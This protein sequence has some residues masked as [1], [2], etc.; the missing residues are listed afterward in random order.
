MRK[1]RG[2]VECDLYDQLPANAKAEIDPHVCNH[3]LN[4]HKKMCLEISEDAWP[5]VKELIQKFR[6]FKKENPRLFKKP[7]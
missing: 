4:E 1:G 7:R 3:R 5:K 6:R 2:L